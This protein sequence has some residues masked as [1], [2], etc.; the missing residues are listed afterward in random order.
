MNRV[1]I[2]QARM[3]STR[4]PGKVLA[5]IGGEPM[6]A[7]QITRLRRAERL[8]SIAIATTREAT[9]DPVAAL[10]RS[11][12]LDVYR[13]EEH[14]VLSRYIAAAK[15]AG[16]E[17]VVRITGDCPLIAPEIVDAVVTRIEAAC[18]DYASNTLRRT[19]P[20][21]LDVEALH[22]DVLLRME[23]LA[24]S[25]LAR[26]HVTYFLH[27][28]RPDLFL[29]VSVEDVLDNSDLRWTVDTPADLMAVRAIFAAL[30]P[31]PDKASYGS[32]LD[33]VRRTPEIT[34]INALV[35][36]KRH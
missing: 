6:L 4:L 31:D 5:D 34:R 11:L 32:I 16:A 14:D 29:T 20:R 28:E 30:G 33:V 18:C 1:A 19:Y 27:S 8:D 13:G 3:T 25:E 22:L 23:R 21:G 36:Q 9:D 17:L 15:K 24:T 2:V 10:G 35:E 26:E 12:G 7:R